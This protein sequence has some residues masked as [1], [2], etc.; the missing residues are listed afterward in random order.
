[1]LFNMKAD[2]LEL[3][4]LLVDDRIT[5]ES[6]AIERRLGDALGEI[7]D[8]DEVDTRCK[9]AQKQRRDELESTGQLFD[10]LNKRGFERTAEQLVPQP[11][12]IF[13][14]PSDALR[15]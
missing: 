8:P 3:D 10:E 5:D 14:P 6:R 9:A 1:M 7:C 4:D 13:E 15:P 12:S 11:D 2:P